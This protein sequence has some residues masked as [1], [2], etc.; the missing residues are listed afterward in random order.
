MAKAYR[1]LK[2]I[3]NTAVD[4]GRIRRNPCRIKGASQETSPERPVL[5]VAQVYAL[6]EAIDRRYRALVLLAAF[7]SLRWGELAALRRSDIDLTNRTIRVDSAAHRGH[8]A[9]A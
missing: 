3:M 5:T 4:D 7:G 2:A 9:A 8:G 1:L 6:A